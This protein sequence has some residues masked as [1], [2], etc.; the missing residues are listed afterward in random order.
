MSESP[1]GVILS[2]GKGS[3]IDPFNTHFPKPM[4]PILNRPI[5]EHQIDQMKAVGIREVIIVVGHL[6]E[7]II[8]HVGD[9]SRFGVAVKYVE[10]QKTLGI[11]HAVMQ[12]ERHIDRHFLLYLG[13]ILYVPR[14]LES[15]VG[16]ARRYDAVVVLAAKPEP[17]RA[18]ISKN[19]L[20]DT[21]TR[22]RVTRVIE[23]PRYL[24][25]DLKGCGIYYFAPEFFDAVRQTPRTALRDEYEI[26]TAIQISID[27]GHPVHVAPVVEWDLNI[28]FP[29]DI[30]V[31]N[32]YWLEREGLDNVVH[33]SARIHPEAKL[34][35]AV[36]GRNVEVVHPIRLDDVVVLPET[37]VDADR[38]LKS[39]VIYGK[40]VVECGGE[41]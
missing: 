26:T 17:N 41:G 18:A 20:I 10:Q 19:F 38:D 35:G 28:T 25:N 30:L 37:R 6:K 15:M 34:S 24:V 13:D 7:L 33:E 2:A 1:V 5:I 4:L 8:N 31:G 39:A 36:I 12:L 11:A 21:D 40:H 3:R 22:G 9:G 32:R 29:A 23:K 16:I 14:D 27:M